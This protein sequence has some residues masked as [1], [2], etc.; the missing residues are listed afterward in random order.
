MRRG[1]GPP[2]IK[3]GPAA[4]RASQQGG[5]APAAGYPRRRQPGGRCVDSEPAGIH[6]GAG[7]L[8]PWITC[9]PGLGVFMSG[10]ARIWVNH[11]AELMRHEPCV[12]ARP[13]GRGWCECS[14]AERHPHPPVPERLSRI[15][16]AEDCDMAG[17]R[18]SGA[19]DPQ[20]LGR[21]Q[22]GRR[23]EVR[24]RLG[25]K[26]GERCT[27]LRNRSSLDTS[28]LAIAWLIEALKSVSSAWDHAHSP[29]ACPA[30]TSSG[31]SHRLRYGPPYGS[32]PC[33]QGRA[34]A[35]PEAG[36]ACPN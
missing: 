6:A 1:P 5:S 14:W 31:L 27:N 23:A 32:A 29:V 24:H 11:A 25:D 19:L 2:R 13:L 15:W 10:L 22:V 3:H 18:P 7:Q 28:Q 36:G 9:A 16:P 35:T 20:T 12:V 17:A 33:P 30:T 21:R 4:V 34:W 26:I 8:V